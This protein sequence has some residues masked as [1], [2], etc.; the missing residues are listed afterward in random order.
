MTDV[1]VLSA[2]RLKVHY[3]VSAG[4]LLRTKYEPLKAVDDVSFE[5]AEGETLGVVGESG[6]GKSTLGRAAL[7]LTPPTDGTVHWQGE[8]VS[9]LNAKALRKKRRD[10]QMIFQDPSSSL[11]PRMTIFEIVA[12]PLRSF[13]PELGEDEIRRRV[14]E[15]LERVELLPN[16]M[17]R[18]PHEFSGGQCQRI[19]IARAVILRPKMLVLDEPVSALD[20]SVQAQI[21]NLLKELQKDL[22]LAFLF[23]SHDLS[24]VRYICDRILVMYLGKAVE[25]GT[26]EQIFAN[27]QHPYT[28]TLIAAIPEARTE[29]A[30]EAS[31]PV[32]AGDLPSPINPPPGCRLNSRCAF[33]SEQC[34]SEH[35]ALS[36]IGGG[37]RVACHNLDQVRTGLAKV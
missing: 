15:A 16:T 31:S 24:V 25:I 5:L 17:S 14:T 37:Q 10:F 20:V 22:G 36:D 33:A 1:P 35:P 29:G 11:N 28:K 18:F 26:R 12:E 6:C 13:H 30:A 9:G 19:S 7:H 4:G 32:I 23:I 27:P 8:E 2:D 21:V 34:G 3:P